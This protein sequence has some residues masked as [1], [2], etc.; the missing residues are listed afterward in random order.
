MHRKASLLIALLTSSIRTVASNDFE[1]K[2]IITVDY[3]T[4]DFLNV[5]I[6]CARCTDVRRRNCHLVPNDPSPCR[7]DLSK[8]TSSDVKSREKPRLYRVIPVNNRDDDRAL[9]IPWLSQARSE[10]SPA[11]SGYLFVDFLTCTISDKSKKLIERNEEF[12]LDWMRKMFN[13]ADNYD[14]VV[15]DYEVCGRPKCEI[16]I[17][18]SNKKMENEW[19]F[20]L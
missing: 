13:S 9:F 17:V 8:R 1:F 7:L 18:K 20:E 3:E 4:F 14:V 11:T 2:K 19:K 16:T 12:A 10:E 5:S 6:C 15:A